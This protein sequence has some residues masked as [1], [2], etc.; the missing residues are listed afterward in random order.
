MRG[1]PVHPRSLEHPEYLV[2]LGSL[3]LAVR[4]H[5]HA[6]FRKLERRLLLQ[7][8]F[9]C[10]L[11]HGIWQSLFL[12]VHVSSICGMHRGL[13]MGSGWV[14]QSDCEPPPIS[15]VAIQWSVMTIS[16][17]THLYGPPCRHR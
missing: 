1:V 8:C 11:N 12:C 6:V 15:Q 3:S 9:D 17:S 5:K 16:V 10:F 2:I 4:L 7:A 14:D 13:G